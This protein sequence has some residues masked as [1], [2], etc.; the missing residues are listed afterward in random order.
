[1]SIVQLLSF[2]FSAIAITIA[3]WS[4]HMARSTLE[5]RWRPY[6]VVRWADREDGTWLELHNC[7]QSSA[8][9]ISMSL[10]QEMP[11]AHADENPLHYRDVLHPG[12]SYMEKLQG[13]ETR[14]ERLCGPYTGRIGWNVTVRYRAE[15]D[16]MPRRLKWRPR[17]IMTSLD[18]DL[19]PQIGFERQG[20][21][22]HHVYQL[23]F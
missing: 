19:N 18:M 21:E 6:V 13:A 10:D 2:G 3:I 9:S 14:Y 16:I 23:M 11:W 22:Y 12:E 8:Y 17:S 5:L 4:A 15:R 7:G 20:K 1:M